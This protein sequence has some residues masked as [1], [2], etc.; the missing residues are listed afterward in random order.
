VNI[1]LEIHSQPRLHMYDGIT[2]W[3]VQNFFS[4]FGGCIGLSGWAFENCCQKSG[5]ELALE[6]R[7]GV[8]G[9]HLHIPHVEN[10]DL[11]TEK[12]G[13]YDAGEFLP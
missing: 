8:P 7:Q 1:N 12:L 3:I 4:T 11:R 9:Y 2:Y 10:R 6:I 5:V 13:R